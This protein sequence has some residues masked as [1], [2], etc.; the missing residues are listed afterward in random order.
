[1]LGAKVGVPAR[2]MSRIR[3]RH[4]VPYLRE[5]DPMTGEVIR[6]SKQDAVR[7]ERERPG[8]LV[9]MDVKRIGR[10][11][12]AAAGGLT[13]G[14]HATGSTGLATATSTHSS[15]IAPG[16][17][18]ARSCPTRKASITRHSWPRHRLLR[19]TRH[20]PD[21]AA[22]DRQRLGLPLLPREIC[23]AHQIKQKFIK[24]HC[25]WQNGKVQR[26]NRTLASEWA[27]H[28]AFTSNDERTAALA[29]PRLAVAAL[30]NSVAH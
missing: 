27:Y 3:R 15:M 8:E 12:V 21:R 18:R 5:C 25:P 17:P 2:T 30:N 29:T 19:R 16:W 26:I 7:Y 6:S 22:D 1:M 13:A 28:Q 4:G 10:I 11:P 23:A 9:H 14:R 24:P 20:H